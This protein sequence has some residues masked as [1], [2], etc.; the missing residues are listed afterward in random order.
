MDSVLL[1]YQAVLAADVTLQGLISTYESVPAIFIS[2]VPEGAELPF[3]VIGD[4]I[5][6]TPTDTKREAEGGREVYFDIRVS[7][8]R[9]GSTVLIGQAAERIRR[10]LHRSR[11]PIDGYVPIY[12]EAVGPIVDNDE[13]NYSR[14][15]SMRVLLGAA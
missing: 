9:T 2:E 14:L 15:I 13:D 1:A 7:M 4:P 5:S 3:V 8:V 10:L 12:E 6:D 11:I